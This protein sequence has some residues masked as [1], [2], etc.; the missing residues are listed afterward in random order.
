MG[1]YGEENDGDDMGWYGLV[2]SSAISV[3][4]LLVS[5]VWSTQPLMC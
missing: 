3:F 1:I 5:I 2:N 4:L